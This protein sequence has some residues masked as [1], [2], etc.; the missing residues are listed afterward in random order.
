MFDV[1]SY[2]V[3]NGLYFFK[4]LFDDDETV[5]VKQIESSTKPNNESGNRLLVQIFQLLQLISPEN[6]DVNI[7]INDSKE[8]EYC[9]NSSNIISQFKTI[10]TPP[11]QV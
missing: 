1:K 6:H 2:S 10:P 11:P 7:A 3:E 9:R 8:Y 5:L 4:G